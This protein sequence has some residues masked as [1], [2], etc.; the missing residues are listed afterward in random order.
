MTPTTSTTRFA[1]SKDDHKDN[2]ED[3]LGRT[4]TGKPRNGALGECVMARD[5]YFE[6]RAQRRQD[7]RILKITTRA[8]EAGLNARRLTFELEARSDRDAV[9]ICNERNDIFGKMWSACSQLT[10]FL[11]ET[12]S[13]WSYS[14]LNS[15]IDGWNSPLGEAVAIVYNDSAVLV[16]KE[17]QE[18]KCSLGISNVIIFQR[19]VTIENLLQEFITAKENYRKSL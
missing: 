18:L 16:M 8:T 10:K 9:G 1:L 2:L 12:K 15:R 11:E 3:N 14:A 5:H 7:A 6:R 4:I 19:L 13:L 17:V